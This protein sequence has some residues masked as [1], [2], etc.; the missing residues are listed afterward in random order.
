MRVPTV[1][2]LL[3]TYNRAEMLRG[4]IRSAL[5][6]DYADFELV[7]HDDCSTDHTPDVVAEFAAD[8][9]LKYFRAARNIGGSQ[10]DTAIVGAFLREH[11]KSRYFLHFNDDDYFA[12]PDLLSRAMSAMEQYP[13]LAVVMGGVAQKYPHKI[14]CFPAN[15]PYIANR[16]IADDTLFAAG[17]F[18]AG[19]MRGVEFLELF[20]ADP[21]NRNIVCGAML[22][23]TDRY[24]LGDFFGD[25][26]AWQ[27]GPAMLC[28]PATYGD[29]FYIDEPC[30]I[31]RVE[32]NCASFR[33]T[34]LDHFAQCLNSTDAAYADVVNAPCYKQLRDK[35][36]KSYLAA[37]LG[38]KLSAR[39]GLFKTNPL[40]DLSGVFDPPISAAEFVSALESRG[41]ALSEET[42]QAIAL[43]D[44][45]A[46]TPLDLPRFETLCA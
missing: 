12:V 39:L 24:S 25:D 4:A 30:L 16:L 15:R 29:V 31:N 35:T 32:R 3:T 11:Y 44:D 37:Y 27:A 42:R 23:R 22:F 8:P 10:G 41:V 17:V 18:P 6:Q 28:G 13:S 14:D 19:L 45:P 7:V 38:N 43:A 46:A 34:Q 9:R 26:F 36:M 40:G 5:A 21:P 20:A 33:G 2:V 1:S